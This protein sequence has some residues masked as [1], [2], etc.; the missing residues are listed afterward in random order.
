MPQL[1]QK[2]KSRRAGTKLVCYN[3]DDPVT[4]YSR[5]AN[6]PW[7][8]EAIPCYD[9]FCT[10][11]PD[12]EA[13]LKAHGA[14]SVAVIP[15]AWDPEVHP[16]CLDAPIT[17]DVVFVGNGDRHRLRWIK[18]LFGTPD[19]KRLKVTVYGHWARLNTRG[20]GTATFQPPIQGADMAKAIA[21]SRLSLNILRRQNETTHNMRTF[22]TPGSGG[23]NVSLYTEQQNEFFP[24]NESSFYFKSREDAADVIENALSASLKREQV[25]KTAHETVKSHTYL[26]RTK[27]LLEIIS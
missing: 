10:Y 17:N 7:V 14:K 26:K 2:Y 11:K 19:F 13:P 3:A 18:D 9:L 23:V 25:R 15:F 6:R 20:A 8:T 5:G 12:L 4:T 27:R 16:T 22:E 24:D 21:G 1:W